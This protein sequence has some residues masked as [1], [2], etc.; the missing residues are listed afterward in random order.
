MTYVMTRRE[1]ED[2]KKNT[3]TGIGS[4]LLTSTY[5]QFQIKIN[6]ILLSPVWF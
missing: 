3:E 2:N 4:L 5:L 1:Y 6:F